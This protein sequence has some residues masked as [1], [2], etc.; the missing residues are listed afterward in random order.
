VGTLVYK[1]RKQNKSKSLR[2]FPSVERVVKRKLSKPKKI[3]P[4]NYVQR[5]QQINQEKR[6]GPWSRTL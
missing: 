4:K 3:K 2:K 6:E 1:P 5:T